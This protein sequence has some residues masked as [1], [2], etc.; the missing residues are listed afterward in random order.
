LDL[1]NNWTIEHFVNSLTLAEIVEIY[2]EIDINGVCVI[3]GLG[4]YGKVRLNLGASDLVDFMRDK[5]N[6]IDWCEI[7]NTYY[8]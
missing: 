6:S 3:S 8:I 5:Y 4:N 7:S 1:G 2:Q